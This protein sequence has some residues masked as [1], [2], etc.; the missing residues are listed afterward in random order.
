MKLE[1]ELLDKI[2]LR[3]FIRHN[4]TLTDIINDI[5]DAYA[6]GKFSSEVKAIVEAS[7]F[8]GYIFNFMCDYDIM[9]YLEQRYGTMFIEHSY[10]T[11]L[12]EAKEDG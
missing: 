7:P 3:P 10:F 4:K 5:E 8:D 9:F 6:D 11:V 12:R 2:D 1:K